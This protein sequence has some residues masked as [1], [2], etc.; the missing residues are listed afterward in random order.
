MAF[1]GTTD[2]DYTR[3][4]LIKAALRKCR[5]YDTDGGAP[6]AYQI[7]DAAEALNLILKE[8]QTHGVLLWTQSELVI[9]LAKGKRDYSI[10]PS[11]YV[12]SDRPLRIVEPRR[13]LISTKEDVPV[14]L[15]SRSDYNQLT[16]KFTTGVANAVFFER[17]ITTCNL[18]VWPVPDD[19]LYQIIATAEI[20]LQD[21][22]S[23]GD[24]A[25]MPSYA[26]NYFLWALAGSLGSEYGLPLEEIGYF[27]QKA[28]MYLE[29][30]LD[31]EEEEDGFQ[32]IPDWPSYQGGV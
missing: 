22:D 27:E 4:Q 9:P 28:S 13:R 14:N 18:Y 11:A 26:Y 2:F 3:D 29:N 15:Y 10:G 25:Y 21:F 5:A 12:D 20:P 32:L 23:S 30:L 1:S 31:F 17:T 6:E 8:V 24:D 16:N 7:R 19:S